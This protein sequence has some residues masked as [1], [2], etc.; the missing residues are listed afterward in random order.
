MKAFRQKNG[1]NDI[2]LNEDA[3]CMEIATA[4]DKNAYAYIIGDAIRTV[5][6]EIQLNTEAGIPYFATV[7]D[8]SDK[9]NIWKHY[10][11]KRILALDFVTG[12]S[13]FDAEIIGDDRMLKYD[14]IVNTIDGE[15]N[16]AAV[17]PTGTGG[18]GGGGGMGG[19]VQNGI[20]Y[21]P[22]FLRD[23]VQV[24]RQ[25]KEYYLDGAVTTE[26]SEETY[27]KNA[28]GTFVREEV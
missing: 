5:K 27:V 4:I 17:D 21:L 1:N 20:F 6:G 11:K 25:L 18:G 24:Y 19:L 26:L 23:G 13:Q 28:E 7:F 14:M 16:I 8:R 2:F 9:L 12:I 15:V 22:V 10:V 3:D